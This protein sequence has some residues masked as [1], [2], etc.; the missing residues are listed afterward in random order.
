MKWNRVWRGVTS[1]LLFCLLFYLVLLSN[2]SQGWLNPVLLALASA[3]VL[4]WGRKSSLL[5]FPLA[6]LWLALGLGSLW[7]DDRL[8]SILALWT[9]GAG[10]VIILISANLERK[11][12][13]R[14]A[15]MAIGGLLMLWSWTD[16]INWYL[17]WLRVSPGVWFP[18][19]PFRLNGSNNIAAYLNLLMMFGVCQM[20]FANLA[21][22]RAA[23]GAYSLSAFLLIYLSSSRGAWVA[24]AAGFAVL[25]LGVLYYRPQVWKTWW[26]S[27]QTSAWSKA[28]LAGLVLLGASLVALYLQQSRHPTH[29]PALSS[30]SE[31]WPVAWKAFLQS[32]LLGHGLNTYSS[33]WLKTYSCPPQEVFL[34]AHNQYLDV[35]VSA[36]LIGLCALIFLLAKLF[37][38]LRSELSRA[39][40]EFPWVM[41]LAGA[42]CVYLVHGVFDGLYRMPFV[43]FSL[44]LMLGAALQPVSFSNRFY[45]TFKA[46]FCGLV[47]LAGLYI[48][49]VLQPLSDGIDL[50]NQNNYSQAASRFEVAVQRAPTFSVAH[51]H[52]GLAYSHLLGEE[53]LDSAIQHFQMAIAADPHWA[54]HHANLAAL[55][56]ARGDL[57]AAQ[58]EI[59]QAVRL[60][61]KS[62]LYWMNKAVIEEESGAS[63]DAYEAY[64]TALALHPRLYPAEFWLQTSIRAD[65]ALDYSRQAGS[66]P[67]NKQELFEIASSGA[68][69]AVDYIAL[70]AFLL[71]EGDVDQAYHYLNLADLTYYSDPEESVE[72]F[73]QSALLSAAQED[74]E[75]AEIWGRQ[76]VEAVSTWGPYGMG[77]SLRVPYAKEVFGVLSTTNQL[78]PQLVTFIPEFVVER[79]KLVL[80]WADLAG[81]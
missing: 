76:A 65:A 22:K 67:L 55:Y 18:S 3:A 24:A 5:V 52:A 50:L 80:E 48:P 44:A 11:N 25:V 47:V 43:S 19:I 41:G 72:Y 34:H 28:G 37:T 7:A 69:K 16:A 79:E 74:W 57:P 68:G 30:R 64:L 8:R 45:Q 26:K 29:G 77:A 81:R 38:T 60:S 71:Q 61:S 59:E 56:R 53:N 32:P 46:V 73:W 63:K 9:I 14:L 70:S 20:I 2:G 75:S 66:E 31:F 15:V 35:L 1:I 13:I 42:L 51:Q 36:G 62:Y 21:W 6:V 40:G 23:W 78:V 10:I 4:I 12:E 27:L 17:Q 54:L 58:A 39:E 33:F 49:W